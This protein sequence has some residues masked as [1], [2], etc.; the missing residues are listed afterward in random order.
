[1]RIILTVLLACIVS[2][3]TLNNKQEISGQPQTPNNQTVTV[4][5]NNGNKH[6]L[7]LSKL[8]ELHS[9]AAKYVALKEKVAK[10][11][12]TDKNV[13]V[14]NISKDKHRIAIDLNEEITVTLTIKSSSEELER[15]KEKFDRLQNEKPVATIRK[16]GRNKFII[17]QQIEEIVWQSE[18]EI[19][20]ERAWDWDS[21][22]TGFG[23]GVGVSGLIAVIIAAL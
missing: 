15:L 9:I 5:D 11:G 19:E 16:I 13:R 14:T 6:E 20:V 8:K 1:M 10:N 2:C 7:E 22:F 4:V 3:G 23:T 17:T 18:F 12:I 21:F